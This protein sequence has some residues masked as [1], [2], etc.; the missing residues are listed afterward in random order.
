[1]TRSDDLELLEGY[2]DD[3]DENVDLLDPLLV[4][5][6][7]SA[8]RASELLR[9]YVTIESAVRTRT[10]QEYL[11][12]R[13]RFHNGNLAANPERLIGNGTGGTWNGSYHME[14]QGTGFGY[15]VDLTHH[16]KASWSEI[17]K[18]LKGWGLHRTVQ[19]EP[20]HYQAQTVDGP[21]EGPFPDWWKA[22]KPVNADKTVDWLRTVEAILHAGD[23]VAANPVRKGSRG[24]EVAIIQA[25]LTLAGFPLGAVDGIAGKRTD[26]A[27]EDYQALNALT[28]D[29]IVGINTWNRLWRTT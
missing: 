3:G 12:D 20:W 9:K 16:G 27:V 22:D 24:D 29:G 25:H 8:Y 5:R 19:G 6:L 23:Q 7:A 15:A 26:K 14:Q 2:R 28:I 10:E 13:Y 11:Y 21:L 17:T 1:M 4:W 18:V